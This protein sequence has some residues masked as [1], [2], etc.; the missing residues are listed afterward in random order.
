MYKSIY[1]IQTS[2]IDS[3]NQRIF[4]PFIGCYQIHSIFFN[5]NGLLNEQGV[6]FTIQNEFIDWSGGY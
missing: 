4:S 3:T 2:C 1:R 6:S 5:V